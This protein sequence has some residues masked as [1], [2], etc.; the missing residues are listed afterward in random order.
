MTPQASPATT[1]SYLD[2]GVLYLGSHYGD[3]QLVRVSSSARQ[4]TMPSSLPVE[5]IAQS[6]KSSN[7]KGKQRAGEADGDTDVGS[8]NKGSVVKTEGSYLEVVQTFQGLSP[9]MDAT[10]ADVDQSGQVQLVVCAGGQGSGAVKVVRKGAELQELAVVDGLEHIEHV[11]TLK[12]RSD[13]L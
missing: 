6:F 12:A 1:L 10:L 8:I 11:W 4:G 3:S 2:N 5:V 9:I 7:S 13:S